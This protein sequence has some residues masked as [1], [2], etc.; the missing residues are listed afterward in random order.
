MVLSVTAV[1]PHWNREALSAI[2]RIAAQS[3]VQ[4]ASKTVRLRGIPAKTNNA[5]TL[6]CQRNP[7]GH[8]LSYKLSENS[9]GGFL[10]IAG[11]SRSNTAAKHIVISQRGGERIVKTLEIYFRD[12]TP[13]TQKAVL[14]LY[15]I[16]SPDEANWEFCP[17]FILEGPEPTTET[18]L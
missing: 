8:T 1:A 12:L 10:Y 3:T 7:I 15:G 14:E 4:S 16:E 2:V 9:S 17:I 18:E 6:K 11:Y 5:L 13:E